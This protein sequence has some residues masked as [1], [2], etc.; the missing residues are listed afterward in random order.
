MSDNSIGL[1]PKRSK[2]NSYNGYSAEARDKKF[3]ILKQLIGKGLL[4]LASGPCALCGDPDSPVE[5]HS[6]DYGEPFL[7]TPPAMY[8]LCRNCHRD[9]LHKR[10]WRQEAWLA[11]IAHVRRGGYS[12][13]LKDRNIKKEVDAYR[14]ALANG[15]TFT[16]SELRP[17]KRVI[18]QEWFAKLSLEAR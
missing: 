9:K 15:G 8:V 2:G 10:F 16:L 5:Y 14:Q 6:E 12:K 11:F 17:Y 3:K 18:G 7:W 1:P 13:D 4:P